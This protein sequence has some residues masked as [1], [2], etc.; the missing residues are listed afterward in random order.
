[1]AFDLQRW[2]NYAKTKVSS[3]VDDGNRTLDRLEAERTAELADKPWLRSSGEAP[4]IDEARARIEWE[5][6]RQREQAGRHDGAADSA[7]SRDSAAGGTRD[8]ATGSPGAGSAPRSPDTVAADAERDVARLELDR[9]ERAS[10]ERLR[11][12]REE[13]GVDD[14]PPAG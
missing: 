11:A 3:T 13:L 12:I 6:T 8:G 2:I 14:P 7:S 4:T 10:A 5:T 1:M 9:R